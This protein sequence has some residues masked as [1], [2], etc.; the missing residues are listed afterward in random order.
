[1]L[2]YNTRL[3]LKKKK[4]RVSIQMQMHDQSGTSFLSEPSLMPKPLGVPPPIFPRRLFKFTFSWFCAGYISV[5]VLTYW[6]I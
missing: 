5:I 1:M 2:K 4:T 6:L 3:S